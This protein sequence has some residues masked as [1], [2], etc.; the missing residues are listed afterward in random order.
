MNIGNTASSHV[1]L[2]FLRLR[3]GGRLK[4]RGTAILAVN[5]RAGSPCHE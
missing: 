4:E 3:L 1:D 5:S 2:A